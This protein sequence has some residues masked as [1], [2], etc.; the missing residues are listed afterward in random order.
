MSDYTPEE[1]KAARALCSV[2]TCNPDE[3]V[4]FDQPEKAKRDAWYV[5]RP[6]RSFPAWQLFVMDIR[7]AAAMLK[8]NYSE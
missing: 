4:T 6:A 7:A 8:G 5:T 1:E 2:S 3:L